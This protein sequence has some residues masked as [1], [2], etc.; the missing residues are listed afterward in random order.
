MKPTGKSFLN[1][2][3]VLASILA[4]VAL[5]VL[6]STAKAAAG[7]ITTVAGGGVGDGSLATSANLA[8]P[9]GVAADAAGNLV[10]ALPS[11]PTGLQAVAANG[12]VSLS[13]NAVTGATSYILYMATIPW[14]TWTSN[15]PGAMKHEGLTAITFLH[16]GL[17]NGTTHYFAVSAVGPDGEGPQSAQVS[18]TPS[19][20]VGTTI[21]GIVTLQG[22]TATFPAGV[23]HNIARVALNPGGV[24][25]SVNADGSFTIPNVPAGTYTLTASASG[26]V[27]RERTNDVVG[28]SAVVLPS[29]QLRCG[30]VNSDNFVNISDITSTV[31]SFG[32]TLTNR[33][34]AQGRFVDQNGDGFVS[35]ND[36]TCVVSGFG[37]TNPLEWPFVT[38]AGTAVSTS[39]SPTT[40]ALASVGSSATV[41]VK[42]VGVLS[43]ADGVQLNIQHSAD[44]TITSPACVGIFAGGS[45]VALTPTSG[46]T[47]ISCFLLSGNVS[48]TTG[49]VMTFVVTRV[50]TGNPL[51]TFEVGG[52]F[53][54]QF[55][56]AG[57]SINPG[58]TNTLQ[59]LGGTVQSTSFSPT[60]VMLAVGSSA[61]VTVKTVGVQSAADGVQLNIQHSGDV[62]ITSPACVGIFAGS[63]P[64]GPA[65]T[66]GGTL[67]SCFF[68][69]GAGDVK[70]TTGDVM[71]FVVTRVGM[72]SPL[73][74][75]GLGGG[76]GTQFSDAGTTL[77]PGVTNTLQ[78]TGGGTTISGTVTLQGRT[79]TF[80]MGVGHSLARVALNPGGVTVSVNA[81]GSFTI[82][83]VPAGIY[84]LTASASGYVSRERTNEVVV[85]GSPV[86]APTVQ[87]RCG[88]VNSDEFVNINDITA[89]V[90]SFGK[91]LANRVDALG[92]F[93]DQNGDTFV[94]INDITCV[95]SGFGTTSP[96]P[97]P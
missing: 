67:I 60:T 11:A 76:F 10:T 52:A 15:L 24:T 70:G 81:D 4:I 5:A 30:L 16:D 74:T 13:W 75:L 68:G 80:P 33:V 48:G 20:V 71:T 55:S 86:M 6:P 12:Q 32:K 65:A 90:A 94:N 3:G 69:P 79:A 96:L 51:L 22:R 97:W 42:T 31:A 34:D 45:T 28:S 27:S 56:D 35:I 73:L 82:P 40:M 63:S 77:G 57:T 25:V 53:G 43:A 26:Y 92:R 21:S 18:A 85:A 91:T 88:L 54:T 50:G 95:V 59:I 72:G 84:T 47:F 8:L 46:G 36:I 14:T 41:T 93:V 2:A 83:N 19:A 1:R 66:T 29:V 58:V 23:G 89:T 64:V 37:T 44:V 49:D 9:A 61:T 87:L 62:T 78:I 7:D 38:T 17:P 39:F